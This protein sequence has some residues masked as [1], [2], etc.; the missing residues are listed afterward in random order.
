M[1]RIPH[2]ARLRLA[3]ALA[4]GCILPAVAAVAPAAPPGSEEER[5]LGPFLARHW[6]SLPLPPQGPAPEGWSAPERSLD[7]ASCGA[8]HPQQ[9]AQWRSSLHAGAYSPGFS[10]QLIEGGLA[11]P[12]AIRQCQGCHAPLAEQQPFAASG[13]AEPSFDAALRDQGLVCAGCHVR[14]HQR[15]G[16]PRRPELPAVTAA[17]PHGGFTARGEFE[18]SRF[19]ATCHQFFDDPGVNG[20]PVENTWREWKQS[21]FA[22]EGRTCQSCHMP[23]RAHTW[24]GI[25]DPETV[26]SAVE[27]DLVPRA[28][29]GSELTASLVLA[30]REIGHA[31][32]TYVTPR[33]FLAVWQEDAG[34]REIEGSRVAATIGREID[35]A[36]SPAREVFDTRVA[37]GEAVKLDY[38]RPREPGSV[39]LVGRVTVDPDHHYRGVFASLLRDLTDPDA[40]TRIAEAQRRASESS[41]VLFETRRSL[42]PGPVAHSTKP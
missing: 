3:L 40:R 5:V 16:P 24:R 9:L 28:L 6:A 13:E 15:Y 11:E 25:H 17:L 7:P 37:P 21:R 42:P 31:F 14:A 35:F 19:C 26:R 38:A 20:K 33:V 32:P 4:L 10:G 41:Y 36:A 29:G 39:A 34:G 23:D 8:C 18:E 2:G 22:A 27:V 1:R 30:S 12:L